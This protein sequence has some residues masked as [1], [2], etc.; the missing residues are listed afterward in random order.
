[1]A[2]LVAVLFLSTAIFHV[3]AHHGDSDA[4]C[5]VCQVQASSIPAAPAP[6]VVSVQTVE[7]VEQGVPVRRAASGRVAV[8]PGRAP[9]CMTA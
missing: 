3:L 1:L 8:I 5:S 4:D 7:L 6:L 2:A 9:P